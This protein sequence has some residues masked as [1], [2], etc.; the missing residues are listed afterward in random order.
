MM[1]G[2][3]IGMIRVPDIQDCL[4]SVSQMLELWGI[5]RDT[6]GLLQ[7]CA[8]WQVGSRAPAR[9]AFKLILWR[10]KT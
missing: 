8:D 9:T 5:G 10:E 7:F 1:T 3:G 4:R 6:Y 2:N